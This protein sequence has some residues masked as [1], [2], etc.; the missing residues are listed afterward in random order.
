MIAGTLAFP[1][2]GYTPQNKN[3]KANERLSQAIEYERL[4]ITDNETDIK[5]ALPDDVK[6]KIENGEDVTISFNDNDINIDESVI[7]NIREYLKRS[8]CVTVAINLSAVIAS[9]AALVY[10]YKYTSTRHERYKIWNMSDKEFN[11]LCEEN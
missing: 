11:R 8:D 1:I 4:Y 6:D 10:L 7:E 2:V 9:A 3:Q 5:I